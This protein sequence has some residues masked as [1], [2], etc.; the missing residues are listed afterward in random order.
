VEI[1]KTAR[2]DGGVLLGSKHRHKPVERCS[3]SGQASLGCIALLL[4]L[5]GAF[6]CQDSGNIDAKLRKRCENRL[7]FIN[8]AVNHYRADHGVLPLSVEADGDSPEVACTTYLLPYLG[9]KSSHDLYKFDEEWNSRN[10][11]NAASELGNFLN[12]TCDPAQGRS[13]FLLGEISDAD[14]S[15]D[16]AG[17]VIEIHDSG[18]F[19]LEPVPAE[20]KKRLLETH[21]RNLNIHGSVER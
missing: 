19:F 8:S 13:Y 1:N 20:S 5:C 3:D 18:V 6:G 11:L 9:H 4:Y 2:L 7:E 12:C 17:R 10:N 16:E 14:L 21:Q 15:P